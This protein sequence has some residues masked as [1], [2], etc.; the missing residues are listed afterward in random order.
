MATAWDVGAITAEMELDK[1]GWDESVKSVEQDQKTMKDLA[2]KQSEAM[3]KMGKAMTIAGAAI[4]GSLGLMVS[5]ASESQETTAKFGT[6]FEEVFDKAN[7]SAKNLAENYGLSTLASKTMLSATG[8]LLTGLGL[9]ADSALDLSEQTQQLSVD[10]ASFTN[11]SGGAAGASDALTKAMLGERESVKALGIVI[12]EEMVKEQLF[13]AGKKGLTGQALLQA[14]AEATLVIALSQ[15]KNAIGDYARTSDSL[16]NKQRELKARFEDV[17]VMLGDKLVP[18]VTKVVNKVTEIVTSFSKWIEKN[19]KLAETIMKVSLAVGAILLVG[20][21]LL[22]IAGKLAGALTALGITGGGATVG[23]AS[24][25][26]SAGATGAASTTASVG[27]GLLGTAMK[28]LL[29]P[30]GLVIAAATAAI[31]IFKKLQKAKEQVAL[32]DERLIEATERFDTKLRA[33]A[34]K[35][36]ITRAELHKLTEKYKGNTLALGHAILKGK[37]G[38]ALQKA[39]A[40]QGKKNVKAWEDQKKAVKNFGGSLNTLKPASEKVIKLIAKMKDE[41]KKDTLDEFE[42]RKQKAEEIFE[43][44]KELLEKEGGAKEDFV[45]NEKA[46]SVKLNKIEEDR[47]EFIKKE[48]KKKRGFWKDLIKDE[49]K[50]AK[51]RLDAERA[52]QS[53]IDKLTLNEFDLRRKELREQIEVELDA[54][55]ER[56]GNTQEFLNKKKQLEDAYAGEFEQIQIDQTETEREQLEERLHHWMGFAEDAGNAFGDF[57]ISLGDKNRTFKEKWKQFTSD[58]KEAFLGTL[59]D[60]VKEYATNFLKNMILN[61][62]K[63]KDVMTEAG[64]AMAKTGKTVAGIGEGI[65]KMIEG[66]AKGVGKAIEAL[67]TGIANAARTLASAAPQLLIVAGIAVATFA[68]FKLVGA[69]FGGGGKKQKKANEYLQDTRNFLAEIRNELVSAFKPVLLIDQQASLDDI[70]KTGWDLSERSTEQ[71]SFLGS[72]NNWL[73]KIY[74]NTHTTAKAMKN[75]PGAAKGGYFPNKTIATIAEDVPEIVAPVPVLQRLIQG[76]SPRS[77]SGRGGMK[78]IKVEVNNTWHIATLDPMTM[79]DVVRNQIMPEVVESTKSEFKTALQEALE[80]Q[81]T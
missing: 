71:L 79:K 44:R 8:D 75:L 77:P 80:V 50:F 9:S 74:W 26:V 68:A 17:V 43:I 2:E 46:L 33:I 64:S 13:L 31:I 4:I 41:I 54:L 57:F 62:G 11:F 21:P 35:A 39:M 53:K 73:E 70:K 76:G 72:I 65:G 22:I 15:S 23:L 5:K 16:A 3:Q 28:A 7:A 24:T 38:V 78:E 30:I 69:L 48:N 19:P 25:A 59:G 67:A 20:G 14:K 55:N 6:V 27:V 10:L 29:G 81:G 56:L 51:D 40:D 66:L 32:A 61:T 58:L 52:F 1:K 63:V 12:T 47:T 45:T 37:E 60:I 34:D 42:Y 36:G 49:K 18:L